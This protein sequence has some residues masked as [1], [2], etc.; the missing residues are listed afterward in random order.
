MHV[1]ASSAFETFLVEDLA[2]AFDDSAVCKLSADWALLAELYLV[3]I[4]AVVRAQMLEEA[5]LAQGAAAHCNAP[6]THQYI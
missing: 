2:G 1:P 5:Y 6:N 4:G 3:V